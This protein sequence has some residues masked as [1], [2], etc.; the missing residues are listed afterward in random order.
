MRPMTTTMRN[1]LVNGAQLRVL[2]AIA[3]PGQAVRY[4]AAAPVTLNGTTYAAELLG[5]GDLDE[6]PDRL[7]DI[8]VEVLDTPTH[9][10]CCRLMAEVSIWMWAVGTSEADRL[11]LIRGLLADPLTIA[12]GKITFDVLA[13]GWRHNRLMGLAIDLV[14]WPGADPDVVGAVEPI[15]YGTHKRHKCLAVDAG[16][17]NT[18]AAAVDAAAT[19]LA[20]TDAARFPSSGWVQ[21]GDEVIIYTGKSGNSLTGCARGADGTEAAPHK[22]GE[23]LGEVRDS[24]TFLVAGHPVRAIPNVYVNGVLQ[25]GADVSVHLNA[26]GKARVTFATQ[27]RLEKSAQVEVEI[28]PNLTIHAT[29]NATRSWSTREVLDVYPGDNLLSTAIA[30]GMLSPVWQDF[31]N[32]RVAAPPSGTWT[33]ARVTLRYHVQYTAL[34]VT[35]RL[36]VAGATVATFGVDGQAGDTV[37]VQ[38]TTNIDRFQVALE[39][40]RVVF[41][42]DYQGGCDLTI[43]GADVTYTGQAD[44]STTMSGTLN[45]R[46][47]RKGLSA[48]QIVIGELVEVDCEGWADDGSGTYTG[49]PGALIDNAAAVTRHLLRHYGGASAGETAAGD[50]PATSG[51]TVRVLVDRRQ[52]VLDRVR[53]LT[54]QTRALVSYTSGR[55]RRVRRRNAGT[56]TPAMTLG[57][58]VLIRAE[59]GASLVTLAHAGL[60]AVAN[61][62]E[63]RAGLTEAGGWDHVATATDSA[64]QAL[65]GAFD[66][67]LDLPMVASE[68]FAAGRAAWQLARSA[69]PERRTLSLVALLP[70]LE[71]EIGDPVRVLTTRTAI[72]RYGEVMGLRLGVSGESRGQVAATIEEL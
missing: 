16:A 12:G 48:S 63:W 36:L 70:L 17:L 15:L 21:V 59:D 29:T 57:D 32:I 39:S 54:D 19:T 50:F 1:A 27:P 2:A 71:L 34:N 24:Y 3:Y 66:A 56:P 49:A 67:D 72:D 23:V 5:L 8:P 7:A 35:H 6:S 47:Y 38:L 26:G 60:D 51:D 41:G 13:Y 40:G 55:W 69:N 14:N 43:L 4:L 9:R 25:S 37:T 20:L 31:T 62:L 45:S 68:P 30:T 28:D 11:L 53:D 52:R 65:Y 46:V 44:L 42:Q 10:A 58:A 64:S 22:Q 18:L 33:E 61:R